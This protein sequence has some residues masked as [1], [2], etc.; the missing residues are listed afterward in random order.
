MVIVAIYAAVSLQRHRTEPD[1][2]LHW[3]QRVLV[4]LVLVVGVVGVIAANYVYWTPPGLDE[5]GGVQPRYLVPLVALL[6]VVIGP[7]RFAVGAGGDGPDPARGA[8]RARA[9]RV[10]RVGHLPDA[11]TPGGYDR[12]FPRPGV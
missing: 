1:A 3:L 12:A 4:V 7:L 10:P 2:S 9:A 8:A 6:P 11:L 5:V